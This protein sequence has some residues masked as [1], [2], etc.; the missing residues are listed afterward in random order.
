MPTTVNLVITVRDGAELTDADKV[1]LVSELSDLSAIIDDIVVPEMQEQEREAF[2][3]EGASIGESWPPYAVSTLRRKAA[4]LWNHVMTRATNQMLVETGR[5]EAAVGQGVEENGDSATVGVDSGS[6]RAYIAEI[7]NEGLGNVPARTFMRF[8]T[9]DVNA[10]IMRVEDAIATR[11][12]L[13]EGTI[14]VSLA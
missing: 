8:T 12:G 6:G 1:A 14:V 10:L 9:D 4:G 3:S 13:A 5:L 7:Q 2:A 11:L